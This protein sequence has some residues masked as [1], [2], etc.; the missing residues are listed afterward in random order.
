M[1]G[2]LTTKELEKHIHTLYDRIE[3]LAQADGVYRPLEDYFDIGTPKGIDG[4]FCYSDELG[5]HYGVN[6]RGKQIMN[7]RT[8][9]LVEI[10][11]VVLEEQILWMAHDY[12]R[13]HRIAGEDS[14]RQLFQK[15]IQYWN[16]I[17]GEYAVRAK[18]D[19]K[20][21]LVKAPFFD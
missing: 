3:P 11:F 4:S 21:T 13:K 2:I 16:A 15:M 17:G 10:V 8:H 5:Y 18:Q 12:E 14:R 1:D 9:S 20:E 19:I 7:I 6:E